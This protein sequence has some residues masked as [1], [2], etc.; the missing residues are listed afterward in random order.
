MTAPLLPTPTLNN[1]GTAG[2]L[3]RFALSQ[4]GYREGG[5]NDNIFGSLYGMNNVA[6]CS[7]FVTIMAKLSG[8]DKLVP[9][10]A[11]TPAGAQWFQSKG[12]WHHHPQ[13]G[14]FVYY[15]HPSMGRIGHVGVVVR[16][17]PD[18]TFTTVEGN[19]SDTGSRTGD[20]VYK[21]RRTLSSVGIDNGGGFGRPAYVA[22]GSLP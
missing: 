6:W 13:A 21:L 8:C 14:D 7:E 17:N 10:T 3:V 18:G 15:Y 9:R 1:P 5:N 4:V 2:A 16:V 20:G 22:V 12:Q 11:Y 19:S